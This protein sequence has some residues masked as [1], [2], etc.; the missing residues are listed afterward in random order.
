MSVLL[1]GEWGTQS[2]ALKRTCGFREVACLL[3]ESCLVSV[4]ILE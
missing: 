2:R 4:V 1:L 3:W